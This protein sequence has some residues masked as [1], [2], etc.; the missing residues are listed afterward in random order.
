MMI[1]TN[2]MGQNYNINNAPQRLLA[3]IEQLAARRPNCH[4]IL[5]NVAPF[6][7]EWNNE[8]QIEPFNAQIE[9]WVVPNALVSLSEA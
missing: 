9:S 4:I 5:A 7:G 8:N 6:R 1:G 3:L 2:D